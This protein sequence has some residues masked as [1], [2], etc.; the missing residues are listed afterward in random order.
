MLLNIL[1]I[2]GYALDWISL[3]LA[4]RL[5]VIAC[6]ECKA[7]KWDSTAKVLLITFSSLLAHSIFNV[8]VYTANFLFN[9]DIH[10]ISNIKNTSSQALVL[11]S[12]IGFLRIYK[13]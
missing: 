8:I 10:V 1:R 11:I 13:R 2:S 6:R 4:I 9:V 5:V 12:L 3:Y 7:T